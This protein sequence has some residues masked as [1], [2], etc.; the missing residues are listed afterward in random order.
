MNEMNGYAKTSLVNLDHVSY[1]T[2]GIQNYSPNQPYAH[3]YALRQATETLATNEKVKAITT[4]FH[5]QLQ[6]GSLFNELYIQKRTDGILENY[7]VRIS[8]QP[9]DQRVVDLINSR[10]ESKQI[11]PDKSGLVLHLDPVISGRDRGFFENG[12]YQTKYLPGMLAIIHLAKCEGMI[13]NIEATRLF[14]ILKNA[15]LI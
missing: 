5:A 10:P 7:H 13:E 1:T 11:R 4:K 12:E 8:Y 14:Q 6:P 3:D 9:N 2:D 15:N